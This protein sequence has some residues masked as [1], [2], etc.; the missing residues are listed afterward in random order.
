MD[1]LTARAEPPLEPSNYDMAGIL[2]TVYDWI[3]W[4]EA[5]ASHWE[6][7]AIARD[8]KIKAAEAEVATLRAELDAA[9]GR[10]KPLEWDDFEDG[11]GAKAPIAVGLSYLITR[12]A[13]G[14]FEIE[15]SAPGIS[16]GF[17]GDRYYPTLEV[18]K[19][20]AQA[21]YTARIL[22]ALEPDPAV[23]RMREALKPFAAVRSDDEAG[24]L[25]DLDFE[26]A[27]AALQEE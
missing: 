10:V 23:E 25:T 8:A 7:V 19:A 6:N 26:R 9:R 4:Q 14:R 20:A 3:K 22:A 16:F 27:R 2:D 15:V 24:Y 18:A 12:W 5:E 1:D 13:D 21:D 11:A 17:E